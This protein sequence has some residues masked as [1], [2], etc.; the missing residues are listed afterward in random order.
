MPR[1]GNWSGSFLSHHE[2]SPEYVP[3][4]GIVPVH[5]SLTQAQD[6]ETW[7]RGIECR[8]GKSLLDHHLVT[9]LP[10][11]VRVPGD[12]QLARLPLS[13]DPQLAIKPG[14]DPGC[15]KQKTSRLSLCRCWFALVPAD[16]ATR[17][18]LSLSRI[19][20]R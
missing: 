7:A 15:R 12:P 6:L 20:V 10:G 11:P 19:Y 17:T 3:F 14:H 8:E 1:I 2:L 18:K 5:G 4:T 13:A 16:R 9:L